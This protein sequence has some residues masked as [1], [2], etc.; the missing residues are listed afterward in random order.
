MA[1]VAQARALVRRRSRA[2]VMEWF[3]VMTG[4]RHRTA[5]RLTRAAMLPALALGPFAGDPAW[6]Q[7]PGSVQDF[8]LPPGR[9]T[10]SPTPT[11]AGPVD[12]E[13]P[14]AAPT[15]PAVQPSPEPTP[16]TAATPAPLPSAGVLPRPR[17]PRVPPASPSPLPG[18]QATGAVPEPTPSAPAG[19][20]GEPA[21]AASTGVDEPSEAAAPAVAEGTAPWPWIAGS[22]AVLLALAGFLFRRGRRRDEPDVV[23][24]APPPAPAVASPPATLPK[25]RDQPAA[26]PAP[27]VPAA[28]PLPAPE[29]PSAA[30][31]AGPRALEVTLEA[32]HLSRA[33]INATLS[34]RLTLTNRTEAALGPLR[35]TGDIITAHASLSAADQFAPADEALAAIQQVPA[36]AAGE[37]TT[38]SGELRL[39]I[40]S[41]L[42]I[43]SG[44]ARVFVPLA[45]FRIAGDGTAMT[46]VFVVGQASEQPGGALRPFALDRGPGVDRGL[47]QRELEAPA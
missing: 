40:A 18:S 27:L 9:A 34:Y 20:T 25:P 38:L 29:P 16:S 17:P 36:L 32:R 35:V 42:P 46:R 2:A 1:Q 19:I 5:A 7:N 8:R 10:P 14:V 4:N 43:R 39:P 30:A 41:I 23:A 24:Y 15:R 45:R 21:P 44:A 26:P 37:S 3:G 13:N 12:S 31:Q 11:A 28:G 6:A 22:A 47:G 33:M